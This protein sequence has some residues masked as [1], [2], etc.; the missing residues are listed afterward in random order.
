MQNCCLKHQSFIGVSV[1]IIHITPNILLKC[2]WLKE[3]L[4]QRLFQ[5]RCFHIKTSSGQ[6]WYSGIAL[7][8]WST[9][10][11]IDPVPGAWFI[12][13]SSHYY[14]P[15]QSSLIKAESISWPKIPFMNHIKTSDLTFQ[16]Y[17]YGWTF[18][19]PFNVCE[20]LS[21][22]SI[23]YIMLL[24]DMHCTQTHMAIYR[25]HKAQKEMTKF[26]S[27]DYTKFLRRIW[28]G[29]YYCHFKSMN[30]CYYYYYY[31]L[32]IKLCFFILLLILL[33]LFLYYY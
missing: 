4:E 30:Y 16:T 6:P 3:L 17:H 12:I 11:A 10:R 27:D 21:Q 23:S 25:P 5:V 22:P 13:N 20:Y 18:T 2:L 9:S 1:S 7:E 15:A 31:I 14:S 32:I 33:L 29:L 19:D 28:P 8:C 24:S 26:H